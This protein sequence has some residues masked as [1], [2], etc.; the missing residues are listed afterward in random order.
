MLA[1]LLIQWLRDEAAYCGEWTPKPPM[2]AEVQT[3]LAK[4]K[5]EHN[6]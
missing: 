5:A 2:A 1:N 3:E 4:Q 6:E